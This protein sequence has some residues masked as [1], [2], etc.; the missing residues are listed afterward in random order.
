ML[1]DVI[2][3]STNPV[4]ASPG[5]RRRK[6]KNLGINSFYHLNSSVN[7]SE[8]NKTK[9]TN[10]QKTSKLIIISFGKLIVRKNKWNFDSVSS[11]DMRL[12]KNT[13]HLSFNFYFICLFTFTL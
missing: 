12:N 5:H 8:K 1:Y 3:E 4:R 2:T 10:K 6:K 13:A 9:Q 11:S 7:L